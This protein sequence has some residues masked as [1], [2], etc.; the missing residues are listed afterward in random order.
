MIYLDHAATTP[1]APDVLEAML[2]WLREGY[3]NASSLYH[4]G[5]ASRK[6]VEDAR[7]EIAAC[8]GAKPR[9]LVFTSGGSESDTAAICGLC[10]ARRDRGRHVLASAIEHPAVLQ[11]LGRLQRD[12]FETELLPVDGEGRVSP[13]DVASRLRDETL[14]VCVMHA[15]NE[16]GTIQPVA[17]IAAAC[18]AR[19]VPLHCD[20]VQT[21]GWLPL[22]VDTLR[23]DSLAASA[24]KLYGPKGV[25]LL[26]LRTGLRPWPWVLGGGQERNRRAGTENVAGIVGLAAAWRRAQASM[27]QRAARVAGL[28]S[29][30]RDGL[31]AIPGTRLNGPSDG[32]LPGHVNVS[33]LGLSGESLMILLDSQEI[34]VSTGS[35][36]SSG[37]TEPS[38]VLLALDG[39]RDRAHGSLRLTLGEA[40][41]AEEIETV[42]QAVG[43]AVARLRQLAPTGTG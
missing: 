40:T 18:A 12:G 21:A 17:E 39:D 1:L 34:A 10:Y 42:L 20:A 16:L 30:L 22:Q 7:E 14:L 3:G 27:D 37:A 32:G 29:R 19:G 41:T 31:L 33:F 11:S 6:A 13:D 4:L 23:V 26:Y 36:C 2:P 24:H 38:H 8:L 43:E 25:G 9:E 15:N 5:R 35:A 28:A